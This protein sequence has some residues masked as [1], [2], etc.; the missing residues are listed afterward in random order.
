MK[1]QWQVVTLC[2]GMCQW[3]FPLDLADRGTQFSPARLVLVFLEVRTKGI[4][5]TSHTNGYCL[6]WKVIYCG[7]F[8]T[9]IIFSVVLPFCCKLTV[10]SCAILVQWF[11][12]CLLWEAETNFHQNFSFIFWSEIHQSLVVANI[13]VAYIWEASLWRRALMVLSVLQKHV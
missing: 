12:K 3:M 10:G 6:L 5:T 9:N 1:S 7:F 13:S 8:S 4:A 2:L 11:W